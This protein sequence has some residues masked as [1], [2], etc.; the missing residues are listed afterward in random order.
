MCHSVV[1]DGVRLVKL[2]H[3]NAKNHKG[4]FTL[5]FH[6][7]VRVGSISNGKDT[8]VELHAAGNGQNTSRDDW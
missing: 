7:P 6:G 2:P 4:D 8:L 5:N 1:H 3:F